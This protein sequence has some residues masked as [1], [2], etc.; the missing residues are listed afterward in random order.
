MAPCPRNETERD[1]SARDDEADRF[2]AGRRL[3]HGIA[4]PDGRES[5]GLQAPTA[6]AECTRVAAPTRGEDTQV[7]DGTEASPCR[8]ATCSALRGLGA[9][10][11]VI[12]KR[13]LERPRL[14]RSGAH[15]VASSIEHS[16]KLVAS[17]QV[18][19]VVRVVLLE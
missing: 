9:H 8:T 17:I 18:I 2:R 10:Y 15:A 1:G 11:L 3:F 6:A 7:S 12:K 19:Q 13:G 14:R 16:E 5:G 4:T